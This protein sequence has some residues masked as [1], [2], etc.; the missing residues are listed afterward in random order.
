MVIALAVGMF[1]IMYIMIKLAL[2]AWTVLAAIGLFFGLYIWY[3]ARWHA[4]WAPVSVPVQ[5]FKWKSDSGDFMES[6]IEKAQVHAASSTAS[7]VKSETLR[8]SIYNR[9][10]RKR[11]KRIMIGDDADYLCTRANIFW[12]YIRDRFH[13]RLD[14]LVGYDRQSGELVFHQPKQQ[15]TYL[16]KG[17]RPGVLEVECGG[18]QQQLD[19]AALITDPQE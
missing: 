11:L 7:V 17:S 19:L 4:Y 8:I 10:A 16:S 5:S 1:L 3:S 15:V 6:V 2:P 14:G 18:V 12:F 13:A 9:T